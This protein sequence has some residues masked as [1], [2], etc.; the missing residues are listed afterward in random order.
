MKAI[1]TK[2]MGYRFRS[3]LEARWAVFFQHLGWEWQYEHQGYHIGMEEKRK[4]LPDFEVV[5]RA[6]QHFYVEVKGDHTA[7]TEEFYYDLDFG[8]GPPGFA[9]SGDG[10]EQTFS[11]RG[12]DTKPILILGNIPRTRGSLFLPLL[13]HRKGINV[14]WCHLRGYTLSHVES[15]DL[16]EMN[17]DQKAF[18]AALY[19]GDLHPKVAATNRHFGEITEALDAAQ[20]ARFEH[21]EQPAQG[22]VGDIVK[23]FKS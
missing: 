7:F 8:C 2:W 14:Y 10:L 12:K 20:S 1:E 16:F 6:G 4:W 5:N 23:L 11:F 13:A 19:A 9:D 22:K 18:S 3:R 17:F 15:V 21:G